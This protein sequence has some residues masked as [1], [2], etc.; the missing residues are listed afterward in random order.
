MWTLKYEYSHKDCLYSSKIKELGLV[1]LIYPLN[2]FKKDKN[3]FLTSIHLVR[4]EKLSINKYFNYLKKISYKSEQITDTSMFIIVKLNYNK[5]YYISIYNPSL[6]FLTPDIH[7]E[8]SEFIQ[9][10]SWNRK[11]LSNLI[12]ILRKNKNT[13]HFKILSFKEEKLKDIFLLKAIPT[14]TE[15]QRKVFELA[16]Q[17]GY[18]NYPRKIN[19]DQLSKEMMVSKSNFHEILRRAES[20]L[21]KDIS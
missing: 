5:E 7:K 20:N 8:G 2:H 1:A 13:T 3:L 11:V 19:L 18:Y 15:R 12:K 4:G 16:L 6:I 21:L 10:A 17:R 14:L 9:L